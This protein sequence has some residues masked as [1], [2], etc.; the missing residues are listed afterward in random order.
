M[1][2]WHF[3]F[4]NNQNYIKKIRKIKNLFILII[5]VTRLIR[6]PNIKLI[7]NENGFI[8]MCDKLYRFS[9]KLLKNKTFFSWIFCFLMKIKVRLFELNHDKTNCDSWWL[10]VIAVVHVELNPVTVSY[11]TVFVKLL[12]RRVV[13]EVAHPL[14]NVGSVFSWTSIVYEPMLIHRG[15]IPPTIPPTKAPCIKKILYIKI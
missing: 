3:P 8:H 4:I 1:V 2:F 14:R 7:N 13:F 9:R 11:C 15:K 12:V 5:P 6:I 10:S